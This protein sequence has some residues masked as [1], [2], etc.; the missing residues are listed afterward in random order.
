MSTFINSFFFLKYMH[1]EKP[2]T[3]CHLSM[4]NAS[5]MEN[6]SPGYSRLLTIVVKLYN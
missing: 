1:S 6:Q 2:P 3:F 4:A 5:K